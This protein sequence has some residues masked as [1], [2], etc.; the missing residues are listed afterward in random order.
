MTCDECHDFVASDRS[1]LIV[2]WLKIEFTAPF[3]LNFLDL[4]THSIQQKDFV[5]LTITLG[6][7]AT[8]NQDAARIDPTGDWRFPRSEIRAEIFSGDELPTLLPLFSAR[9]E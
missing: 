9:R 7:K 4:L 5:R 3:R 6:H 1:G 8:H 2:G